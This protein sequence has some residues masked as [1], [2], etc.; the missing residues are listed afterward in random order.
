MNY[1]LLKLFAANNGT[2]RRILCDEYFYLR[3]I[4]GIFTANLE[5]NGCLYTSA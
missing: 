2:N 3:R 1:K 4:I 5:A